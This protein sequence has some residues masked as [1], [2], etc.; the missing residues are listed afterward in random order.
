MNSEPARHQRH[1]SCLQ[2]HEAGADTEQEGI[3]SKE[4]DM[5]D[6]MGEGK[7]P[8]GDAGE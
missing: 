6:D 3:G 1:C 8:G 7:G 2:G 5:S 4:G